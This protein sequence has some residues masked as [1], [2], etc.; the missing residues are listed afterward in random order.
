[1]QNILIATHQERIKPHYFLLTLKLNEIE[2]VSGNQPPMNFKRFMFCYI[3]FSLASANSTLLRPPFY[4][5]SR[6]AAL[7]LGQEQSIGACVY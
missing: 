2:N 6:S 7:R 3:G 4:P 5:P 1:M